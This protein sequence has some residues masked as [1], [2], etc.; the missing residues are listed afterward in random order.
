[1]EI[2]TIKDN[3]FLNDWL[4]QLSTKVT[5]IPDE[6]LVEALQYIEENGIPGLKNETYR[7]IPIESILKKHFR[8]ITTITTT[9]PDSFTIPSNTNTIILHPLSEASYHLLDKGINIY[10][11]NEIPKNHIHLIGKTKS[12][13]RDFFAAL[14]TAYCP[15]ITFI[16]ITQSPQ[17]PLYLKHTLNSQNNFQQNRFIIL[18]DKN[19]EC[20]ILEEYD[21]VLQQSTFYN[22]LSEIYVD[23][24]AKL[25]WINLQNE[26]T[27]YLYT[28]NNTSF[29]LEKS[30]QFTHHQ[31]SLNGALWRNNLNIHI[32]NNEINCN[33][34]GLSIGKNQSIISHNTAIFH[35]VGYSQSNQLYKN[36]ADDKSTVLFN[37]FIRIDKNAQKTN[38]YQS[39]KNILLSD[40]AT[41]FA[42]P[43]LEIYANDVKCS[44]GSSTG[45]LNEDALFYIQ[46]RGIDKLSAQKLLLQAFCSDIIESIENSEIKQHLQQQITI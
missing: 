25:N 23:E 8:K 17:N 36:I 45:N 1:M 34:K 30:A 5:Y 31:I 21:S 19:T 24:S 26:K 11:L 32:N 2:A 40:F 39:N 29:S 12:H 44:H 28:I 15:N 38:A 6:V 10:H 37:G 7:Y 43:Q 3:T 18:I 33:L 4:T 41:I 27:N 46:T 42:K 13:T 9:P 20:T 16:H 22:Q 35:H 14:N